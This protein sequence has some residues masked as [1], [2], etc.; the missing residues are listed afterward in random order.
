[1]QQMIT[2]MIDT[3]TQEGSATSNL[4]KA[5]IASEVIVNGHSG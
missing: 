1:M 2:L 3:H 5:N 4:P